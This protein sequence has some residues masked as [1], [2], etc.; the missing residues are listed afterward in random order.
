MD[1]LKSFKKQT[2]KLEGFTSDFSD[3][4]ALPDKISLPQRS[5]ADI[6]IANSGQILLNS[7]E[8]SEGLK[9]SNYGMSFTDE[10]SKKF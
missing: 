8:I 5:N 7:A 10:D 4:I 3:K 2:N 1:V 9:P 6:V